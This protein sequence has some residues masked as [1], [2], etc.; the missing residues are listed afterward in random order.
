MAIFISRVAPLWSFAL[1]HEAPCDPHRHDGPRAGVQG[2][3]VRIRAQ[4][5]SG[6]RQRR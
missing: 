1:A 4:G 5:A 6:R 2:E 3:T